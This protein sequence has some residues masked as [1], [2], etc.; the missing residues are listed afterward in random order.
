MLNNFQKQHNI[1]QKRVNRF[2]TLVMGVFIVIC[3]V[4]ATIFVGSIIILNR[5]IDYVN[6]NGVKGAVDRV[7]CGKSAQCQSVDDAK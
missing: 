7:W 6:E 5:S 1:M 2:H 4:I 3:I